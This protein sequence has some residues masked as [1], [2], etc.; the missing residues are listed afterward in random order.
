MVRYSLPG[1]RSSTLKKAKTHSQRRQASVGPI[2]DK[3]E[4]VS[5][6]NNCRYG[7]VLLGAEDQLEYV[8]SRAVELLDEPTDKLL[9]QTIRKLSGDFSAATILAIDALRNG[10]ESQ[11]TG[12]YN[13]QGTKLSVHFSR[14]TD[15]AGNYEGTSVLLED[16]DQQGDSSGHMIRA[17]KMAILGELAAAVAHE[18][19][20]PLG[21]IMESVRIIRDNPGNWE[22]INR[23]L[24][25]IMQGLERIQSSVQR[26]LAF[27]QRAPAKR[28]SVRL[29][30]VVFQSIEFLRPRAR[31]QQTQINSS[32]EAPDVR[33]YAD[34]HALSQTI[35]NLLNNAL[36]SLVGRRDGQIDLTM[37]LD[38]DHAVVLNIADNGC[39]VPEHLREKIFDPFFT[40]KSDGKGTGL[41]LSISA[42]MIAEHRGAIS[43]NPRPGGGTIFTITLPRYEQGKE[44]K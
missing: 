38:D 1:S 21:G 42:N 4:L 20:N 40:T 16:Q 17:E 28:K 2:K 11:L 12:R 26:V 6:L 31:Q 34:S 3:S 13:L 18:I 32:I 22:K 8:N 44:N 43:L 25:L 9:G 36:D 24:P 15:G 33:V 30:D 41:G 23:F 39:G 10:T 5:L 35:I 19:N 27:G 37:T 7:V 14:S 29:A